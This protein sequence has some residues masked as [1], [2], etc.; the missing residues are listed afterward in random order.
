MPAVAPP[1]LLIGEHS[2]MQKIDTMV[3]QVASAD[4]TVLVTGE[5]K[6]S[7]TFVFLKDGQ[8]CKA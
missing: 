4:A 3:R 2:L 6:V 1:S 7:G 5:E 8:A